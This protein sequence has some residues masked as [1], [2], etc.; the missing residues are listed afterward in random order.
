MEIEAKVEKF[1]DGIMWEIEIRERRVE[2]G[3]G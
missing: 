3:D 1:E 2:S